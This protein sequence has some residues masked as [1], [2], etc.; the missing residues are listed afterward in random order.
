MNYNKYFKT[1]KNI[2]EYIQSKLTHEEIAIYDPKEIKQYLNY[3]NEYRDLGFDIYLPNGCKALD[4]SQK[5]GIEIKFRLTSNPRTFRNKFY[6]SYYPI[7]QLYVIY[8][9]NNKFS[10]LND[11]G[12]ITFLSI[13]ELLERSGDDKIEWV[14]IEK[15]F[16]SNTLF[17]EN[18]KDLARKCFMANPVT[19]FLGAGVGC[20]AGLPK[21]EDLLKNLFD[22]AHS[23]SRSTFNS[24]QYKDL[25]NECADSSIIT[26]RLIQQIYRDANLNLKNAIYSIL[27]KNNQF[28]SPLINI[29]CELVMSPNR[30]NSIITYNYDNLIETALNEHYKH[31]TYSVCDNEPPQSAFPV[32]HVHGLID[33]QNGAKSTIVL[34]ETEYHDIYRRSYHWS[35]VEQ[36]HALQRTSCFFIGLSMNDPNLRRLLDIVQGEAGSRTNNRGTMKHF[37]Y[38]KSDEVGSRLSSN[39]QEFRKNFENI[40]ADLGVYVIWYDTFEDLPL[41][42]KKLL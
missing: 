42:L 26:G 8:V 28:R 21:W 24:S 16:D 38:I 22:Y 10:P 30:V 2:F 25:Y 13:K 41:E 17:N 7:S 37:A 31:P 11:N 3:P 19:L 20:S 29:I 15:R 32:I 33:Y 9:D 40:L 23:K 39:Q 1:E 6:N 18:I 14:E 36:L 27:Y 4:L 5:S 35:N 34:S 12:P